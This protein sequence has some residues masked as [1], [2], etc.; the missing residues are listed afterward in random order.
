MRAFKRKYRDRKSGKVEKTAKW[1]IT[2]HD[3]Q[4]RLSHTWPGYTDK[5]AS[6]AMGHKL[7]RLAAL[8]ASREPLDGELSRWLD[9]RDAETLRKLVELD[10]IERSRLGATRTLDE[11][12]GEYIAWRRRQGRNARDTGQIES[13][14]KRVNAAGRFTFWSDLTLDRFEGALDKVAEDARQDDKRRDVSSATRNRIGVVYAAFVRWLAHPQ[15]R[16]VPGNPLEGW[17]R[18]PVEDKEHRR[19]LEPDEAE[20]MVAAAEV[21]EPMVWRDRGGG[22]RCELSGPDRAMLY[23]LAIETTARR[24][25]LA[26]VRVCDLNTDDDPSIRFTAK[27]GTKTRRTREAPIT[28]ETAAMV[29]A[30]VAGRRRTGQAK[31]FD[32]P[33]TDE[34]ADMLRADLAAA[35]LAWIAE[36][37]TAEERAKR[38]A[39]DFLAERDAQGRR[40]DFHALRVTGSTWLDR[41]GVSDTDARAI[42]GHASSRVRERHYNR[43]TRQRTRAALR[44]VQEYRATGTDSVDRFVDCATAENSGKQKDPTADLTAVGL[45]QARVTGLE[46]AT[47][48]STVRCSNQLSYT[49]LPGSGIIASESNN[50]TARAGLSTLRSEPGHGAVSAEPVKCLQRINFQKLDIL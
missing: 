22:V 15:R 18:A 20:R 39:S 6:E 48:G 2:W 42:T 43:T 14:V 50:V 10:L 49:P 31:A 30:Y 47:F 37:A 36:G 19:A 25:E 24:S 38:A 45:R 8:R 7:E 3:A 23:R 44:S 13:R 11:L 17:A 21:A 35:R 46:P 33:R 9:A 4:N 1:Y 5:A 41:A 28:D 26:R 16:M 27:A 12:L 29:A 32:L 40:V 34:T